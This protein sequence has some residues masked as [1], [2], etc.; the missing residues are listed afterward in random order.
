[1]N[2]FC[3]LET[4]KGVGPAR[5]RERERAFELYV[6]RS[7]TPQQ[8]EAGAAA[9]VSS[10]DMQIALYTQRRKNRLWQSPTDSTLSLPPLFS[11]SLLNSTESTFVIEKSRT[12]N[13]DAGNLWGVLRP[14][15]KKSMV[16]GTF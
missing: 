5:E 4:V 2:V 9:S 16:G 15:N 11:I 13:I 1:M 3:A 8:K 12:A 6:D 7:L 14:V 10:G